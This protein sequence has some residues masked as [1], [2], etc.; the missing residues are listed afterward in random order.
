MY[1]IPSL[2]KAFTAASIA[3]LVE[4]GSL[5]RGTPVRGNLPDFRRVSTAVHDETT[6]LDFMVIALGWWRRTCYGFMITL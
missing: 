4:E 5:W 2:S 3:M 1:H 6:I